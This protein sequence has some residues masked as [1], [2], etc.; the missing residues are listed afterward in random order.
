[1]TRPRLSV[2]DFRAGFAGLTEPTD[3]GSGATVKG[4]WFPGGH[5]CDAVTEDAASRVV[6]RSVAAA[7]ADA[8]AIAGFRAQLADRDDEIA[9]LKRELARRPA[10]GAV[11]ASAR[12]APTI[13]ADLA[14]REAHRVAAQAEGQA[15]QR[16][17]QQRID[18][19]LSS[20]FPQRK[21]RP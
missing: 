15:T 11:I 18:A 12:P 17:R 1:M 14:E 10:P 7:A 16:T 21:G 4:T 9:R 5:E 13:D 19:V 2:R 8:Q 6:P 20:A 3:V